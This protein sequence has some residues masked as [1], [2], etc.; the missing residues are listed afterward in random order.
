MKVFLCILG[1]ILYLVC[2]YLLVRFNRGSFN[3]PNRCFC[4]LWGFVN[5]IVLKYNGPT[6]VKIDFWDNSTN[7]IVKSGT[8]INIRYVR[9]DE[10]KTTV[11][12]CISK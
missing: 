9:V 5:M 8:I 12:F 6:L 3:Y 2:L 10:C 11:F 1:L 4:F 7:C